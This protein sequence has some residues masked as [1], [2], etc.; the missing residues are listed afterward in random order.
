[1]IK[2]I[3][4]SWHALKIAF[5]NEIAAISSKLGVDPYRVMEIFTLDKK[6]N[7][8]SKYHKPG[9]AYG[10]SCLT[11]DPEALKNMAFSKKLEV[12]II[13]NLSQSNQATIKYALDKIIRLKKKN[14]GFLGI[15]F[16]YDGTSHDIRASPIIT[17]INKLLERGYQKLFDKGYNI[18]IYDPYLDER[19]LNDFIPH[20]KDK[21]ENNL[22]KVIEK[23]DILV[24]GPAYP[25]FK[26]IFKCVKKDQ[27]VIDL[28]ISIKEIGK[29][30]PNYIDL[31]KK[32]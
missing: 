29:K 19:E 10:G 31:Y 30:K 27:F 32:I 21:F 14:I 9:F 23:S 20:Y 12:P 4:N 1:M 26:E 15:S 5:T 16:K 11:K 7:I 8:S 2:Y 18:S 13:N 22:K 28:N 25:E 6:L 17:L 3:N 24:I